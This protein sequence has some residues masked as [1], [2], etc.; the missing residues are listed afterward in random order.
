MA[1]G[2]KTGGKKAGTPNKRRKSATV[3]AARTG[4]LP[5]DLLLKMARGEKTPGIGK[6]TRAEIVEARKAAAPY[7]QPRLAATLHQDA[8]KDVGV[9]GLTAIEAARA[10]A[11]A[12]AE[13]ARLMKQQMEGEPRPPRQAL[14]APMVIREVDRRPEAQK[15]DAREIVVSPDQ[16]ESA[17]K[18][19]KRPG[20]WRDSNGQIVLEG[21]DVEEQGMAQ[22]TPLR[23]IGKM[24]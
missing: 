4:A 22:G 3:T 1:R 20:L 9:E 15:D 21:A 6:P 16:V 17:R 18:V 5:A 12:M 8:P 11:F 10:V 7:Y 19:E 13:G 2:F 14:P 24:R 23:V